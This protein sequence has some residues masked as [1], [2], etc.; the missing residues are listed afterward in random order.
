MAPEMARAMPEGMGSSIAGE[1]HRSVTPGDLRPHRSRHS[2]LPNQ[3]PCVIG[4]SSN[5][6]N[7]TPQTI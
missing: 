7:F 4:S 5:S 1:R 6:M 2:A 3:A